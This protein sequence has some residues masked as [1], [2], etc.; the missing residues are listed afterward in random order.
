MLFASLDLKAVKPNE[1]LPNEAWQVAQK[2]KM[3]KLCG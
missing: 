3:E 2:P 1:I